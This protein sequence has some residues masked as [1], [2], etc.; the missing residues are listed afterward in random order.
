MSDYDVLVI[1]SA[2]MDLVV[3]TPRFPGPGETLLG[4]DFATHPGGKGANQAVAAA[5]LGA[6]TAFCGCVG[7]DAFGEQLRG[8]LQSN[9]VD[10]TWLRT[11]PGSSGIAVI[12]VNAEGQNTIVVSPGANIE[13][14]PELVEQAIAECDAPVVLLQLEIPT[15]A[16]LAAI[17]AAKGRTIILNPAPAGWLPDEFFEG[18]TWLTPNESEA[19][20][21]TGIVP[22]DEVTTVRA[23]HALLAKGVQN[24]LITLGA[25][26]CM[27]VNIDGNQHFLAHPVTPV[28]TTAAGDAFNGALAAFL[29]EELSANECIRLA[30]KVGAL[31][32]TRQ[33]AQ[34]AMPNRAEVVP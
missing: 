17:Q 11:V 26:G 13:V 29:A 2:N 20:T 33:G 27:R 6:R 12:Q 7:E 25:K 19:Q 16:V 18:V 4:G 23:G 21:L 8:S 10:L 32:T 28:D 31:A 3:Q 15:D 24:A 34:E 1:G 22:M 9:G 5:R 30:N 14:T